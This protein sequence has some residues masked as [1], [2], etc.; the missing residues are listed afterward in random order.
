MNLP[1]TVFGQDLNLSDLDT[2]GISSAQS[3]SYKHLDSFY[4]SVLYNLGILSLFVYILAY[5]VIMKKAVLNRDKKLI[6][7]MIL[8]A[9]YGIS[10]SVFNKICFDIFIFLAFAYQYRKLPTNS[11]VS[12]DE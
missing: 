5:D 6:V 2:F 4:L 12:R 10:E 1:I 3:V 8:F 11:I 7:T 9:L